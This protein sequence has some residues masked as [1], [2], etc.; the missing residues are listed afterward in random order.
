M[1]RWM[2]RQRRP[3]RLEA[4]RG[5]TEDLEEPALPDKVVEQPVDHLRLG[6]QLEILPRLLEFLGVDVQCL[7]HFPAHQ[8]S[9]QYRVRTICIRYPY[10]APGGKKNAGQ[11]IIRP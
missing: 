4:L 6:V 9:P 10:H 2:G 3:K 7:A 11:G 1:G 8:R 5:R